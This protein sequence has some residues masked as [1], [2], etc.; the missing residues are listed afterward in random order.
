MTSDE[1]FLPILPAAASDRR[2]FLG[3]AAA[4]TVGAALLGGVQ[5]AFAASATASTPA[6]SRPETPVRTRSGL[7]TGVR[8]ALPGVTVYKGIPFAASTAG[9][10]RW[11]PPQPAPS[12]KGVRRADTWG[13]ACP[14]PTT[15]TPAWAELPE[16]SEDCLNLN[17]WTGASSSRE[18]RP[19][20]VWVYGGAR[21][22]M[23]TQ[24]PV[25]D[26]SYL[27]S[28]GLVFVTFNHRVGAF[29][30]LAHPE[31]S[32]ESGHGASGNWGAM[33]T[34][35]ALEWIRRNIG[36][37]GGDPD[38][39]TLAGWSHGSSLVNILMASCLARG[40]YQR[41]VLCAG[42]QYPKDPA[43]GRVAGGYKTLDVAEANGLAFQEFTGAGSLA[44]LRALSADEIVAGSN[45]AGAPATGGNTLDGYVLPSTYGAAMTSGAEIDV[46][47][48]TGNNKDENGASP[49]L[50]MTVAQYR[51][52]ATTTFGDGAEEF[53]ALYPAATDAEAVTSYNDYAR[54]EE[55][56]STFLWGT[57]FKETAGNRSPV[58]NYWWSHVPPGADTGNPIMTRGDAA[59][60]GAYHGAEM[61]YLFG[62][63]KGAGRPWTAKDHRL[64]DLTTTY[65]ADFAATGNPNGHGRG[66]PLT[67]PALRPGKPQTMEL[68]DR[69]GPVPAAGS[70]V[71]YA[72]LRDYLESQTKEY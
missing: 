54:D 66:A 16:F 1:P 57:L 28:K 58:W 62:N 35:A 11:R 67:W 7:V 55:R 13:P 34:V 17:I 20:V 56:V 31:L 4:T 15:D 43:L 21:T 23:W 8:A 2:G 68:G 61:Y 19:V 51:E 63:L 9:K 69:F 65:L 42:V 10:N 14:Q 46:P 32:A 60:L 44:G 5:P 41:A 3:R 53:L 25:Y 26:G 48:L 36:A 50:S 49:S 71:K 24:Q 30:N 39:V 6:R 59:T 47:V 64:A 45:A 52:F 27:A 12:W 70:E 18:R 40:L 22:A 72:F 37:F 33:D 38:R 29:G